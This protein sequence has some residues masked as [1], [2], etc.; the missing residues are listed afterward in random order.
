MTSSN[1]TDFGFY[2]SSSSSLY[3]STYSGLTTISH[4]AEKSHPKPKDYLDIFAVKM[5]SEI[6]MGPLY[7]IILLVNIYCLWVVYYNKELQKLDFFLTTL[8]SATDLLF[9]G[10]IGFVDY[11]LDLWT[12]IIYLC[13]YSGFRFNAPMILSIIEEQHPFL[14]KIC[15]SPF[16]PR[17]VLNLL[18]I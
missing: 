2:S 13:D 11:C 18:H 16:I 6:A 9:T 1:S 10:F 14:Y 8:Q 3:S 7:V 12:G 5:L 17:S 4:W 15:S